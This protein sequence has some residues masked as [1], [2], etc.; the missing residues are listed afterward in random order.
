[1]ST[2]WLNVYAVGTT[3]TYQWY[4]YSGNT[5][6]ALEDGNGIRGSTGSVLYFSPLAAGH[7][8]MYYVE[9]RDATGAWVSSQDAQVE[10]P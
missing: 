2:Q 9:V 3:L 4:K 8:G 7:A 1:G 6:V 5:P 10:V